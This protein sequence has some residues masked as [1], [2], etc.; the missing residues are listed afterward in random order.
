M[1]LD[2]GRCRRVGGGTVHTMMIH[3]IGKRVRSIDL[4]TRIHGKRSIYRNVKSNK[5]P[6]HF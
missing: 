5:Y 1:A 6:F 2:V 4:S 3:G